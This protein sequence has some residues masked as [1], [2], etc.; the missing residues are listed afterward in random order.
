MTKSHQPLRRVQPQGCASNQTISR[1]FWAFFFPYRN[2]QAVA[3][4]CL[5]CVLLTPHSDSTGMFELENIS[6]CFS[7]FPW[8]QGV[9][10]ITLN[11]KSL[12]IPRGWQSL[13]R[14]WHLNFCLKNRD[15]HW[16]FFSIFCHVFLL[17]KD[18]GKLGHQRFG[19]FP[20]SRNSGLNK[21]FG[22]P[23][24]KMEVLYKIPFQHY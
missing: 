3:G 13:F 24:Q 12:E 18:S 15:G 4:R 22:S 8:S 10:K 17:W 1:S 11:S 7:V 6:L 2:D 21:I 16:P 19:G 14:G 9:W 23:R 20:T 5:C